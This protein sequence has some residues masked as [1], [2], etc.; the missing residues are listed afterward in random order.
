MSEVDEKYLDAVAR[1]RKEFLAAAL[2]AHGGNRSQT[3]R[4]LGIQRTYLLRLI[5]DFGLPTKSANGQSGMGG[6][7]GR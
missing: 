5:R 7:S 3:A 1:F 6:R 4:S 2:T